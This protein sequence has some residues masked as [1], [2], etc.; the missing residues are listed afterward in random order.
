MSA[1]QVIYETLL[2]M[3]NHGF[4]IPVKG[5]G[6]RLRSANPEPSGKTGPGASDLSLRTVGASVAVVVVVVL[7]AI[8]I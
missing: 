7:V 8:V 6:P 3:E 5:F 4:P 1:V 2:T